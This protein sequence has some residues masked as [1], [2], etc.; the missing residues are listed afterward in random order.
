MLLMPGSVLDGPIEGSASFIPFFM[1]RYVKF[2]V[3]A[4]Q[5]NYVRARFGLNCQGLAP[6]DSRIRK[7]QV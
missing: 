3:K 1:K 2:I 6:T 7:E 5:M 4:N